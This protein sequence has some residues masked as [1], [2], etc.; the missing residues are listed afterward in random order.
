MST[1]HLAKVDSPSASLRKKDWL[2]RILLIVTP[3]DSVSESL[4]WAIEREFPSIAVE[5]VPSLEAACV[6]FEHP[7]SLVLIDAMFLADIDQYAP[8]LTTCHTTAPMALLR[9]DERVPVPVREVI[10]AGILSG[11]L[12]MNLKLD[13]WLSVIRLMLRGGHYFPLPMLQACIGH[14]RSDTAGLSLP[15][16][17]DD[18]ELQLDEPSNGV[19]GLES[20][21]GRELQILEMVSRGMQNKNI[22]GMLDLSEYTVKIH[23]HHIIRKLGAHNRTEAAAIFH[24][25][26]TDLEGDADHPL[27]S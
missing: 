10:A 14:A 16:P 22:A 23:L 11:V 25:H 5:Q 17:D 1:G 2:R 15:V 9:C 8:L 21:T 7:V 3:A 12:P 13:V 24:A 20:L 6:D 27:K 4:V 18:D 19:G 26:R